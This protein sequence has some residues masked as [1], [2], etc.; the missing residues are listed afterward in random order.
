MSPY[1]HAIRVGPAL[2]ISGLVSM[3]EQGETVGAGNAQAQTREVLEQL[4]RILE[5]AGGTLRDVVHNAIFLRDLGH[6]KA[7][8][9]VYA[10]YFPD[11]PPARYCIRADLVRD[12]F[13]V[14]IS[15]TAHI[16]SGGR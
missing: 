12:D 16:G 7:M 15:S 6:Y 2:Y 3:N 1:S 14:E 10:E 13:L 9:L 4:K 8:N 11:V 5:S